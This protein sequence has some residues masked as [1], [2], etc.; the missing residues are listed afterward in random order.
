[1]VLDTVK[2]YSIGTMICVIIVMGGITS[3]SK[4]FRFENW[5]SGVS[6]L[7]AAVVLR[8]EGGENKRGG[9]VE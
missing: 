8:R 2:K 4:W 3:L 7:I 1:L 6:P 5:S 9:F